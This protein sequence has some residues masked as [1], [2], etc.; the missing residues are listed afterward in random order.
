MKKYSGYLNQMHNSS[1]SVLQPSF[2]GCM[3]LIQVDDQLVNLSEVAQRRPGSFANVSIDMCAIIDRTYRLKMLVLKYS[4]LKQVVF[5]TG[6]I[7][8]I[9][10]GSNSEV[11]FASCDFFINP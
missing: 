8:F 9:S 1:H 7:K 11:H 6:L 5:M 2:Q 3:Q 4:E 10:L